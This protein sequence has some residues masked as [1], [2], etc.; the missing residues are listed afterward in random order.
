MW[1]TPPQE[2]L[3]LGSEADF[4]QACELVAKINATDVQAFLGM[5]EDSVPSLLEKQ[6]S[7]GVISITG[8]LYTRAPDWAK[9]IFGVVDYPQI[10]QALVDAAKDTSISSILLNVK[11]P[12]GSV[13]GV[14]AVA[15]LVKQIDTKVKPVHA[16]ADGLMAS[17]AYWIGSSAR[18]IT[19]DDMADV[20]SIGVLMVHTEQS[21]ALAEAGITTT[22]LRAGKYKALLNPVEPLTDEARA[23]A[24]SKLDYTY[25]HFMGHVAEQR[26]MSYAVADEKMGQ[27]RVFVGEQAK[28][29]GL[30][31]EIAS[32]S[33]ALTAAEKIASPGVDT[34]KSLNN[35]PKK[36]EG[37]SNMGKKATLTE[38][39]IAALAAGAGQTS[40]QDAAAAQ[41][42]AEA[43]EQAA[44]ETAAPAET[45]AAAETKPAA[46]ELVNLRAQVALLTEQVSI[47]NKALVD[48]RVEAAKF[49]ADVALAQAAHTSSMGHL[50]ALVSI[51][52]AA[53]RNMHVALGGSAAHVDSLD[54]AGVI[55]EHAKAQK[56]FLEK[57]KAGGVAA[58]ASTDDGSSAAGAKVSAVQ[59]ARLAA[60]RFVK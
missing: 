30:V 38:A 13:S 7:V 26:G 59:K 3:W 45:E 6:G 56:S 57:F 55:A 35:N 41:A 51:A 47:A 15:D 40:E 32:F 23:E 24:Q 49:Q 52:K 10:E 20:G 19:A 58:A 42:S 29:V 11:S 27:G 60:T 1:M 25:K 14:T 4:K 48:A 43:Q 31:D 34:R 22:V 36:Q 8:S 39:E 50:D 5:S 46:D 37:L 16:H 21:K 9:A 33:Q 28:S 17:A 2:G 44:A 18:R 53:V 12:G 54:T